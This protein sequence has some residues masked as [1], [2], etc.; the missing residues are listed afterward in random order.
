METLLPGMSAALSL[1]PLFVHFP[2]AFWPT[3]LLF[4]AVGLF[5]NKERVLAAGR[6]MLYLAT[7]SAVVALLFGFLAASELGHA[8][9]GHEFVHVHRNWMVTGT[10][11]SV[12]A[13]GVSLLFRNST[14]PAARWGAAATLALTVAVTTLGADRGALLVYKYGVGTAISQSGPA[15]TEDDSGTTQDHESEH[16]D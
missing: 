1:H 9:A 8:S 7:A 10:V 14:R 2:L 3:A 13:S 6:I 5:F 15:A 11:L 12:V 16:G 4:M